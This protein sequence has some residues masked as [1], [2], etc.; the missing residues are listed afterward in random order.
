MWSLSSSAK[1][2]E[3]IGVEKEEA[4]VAGRQS[5]GSSSAQQANATSSVVSM[6][7]WS[8][9]RAGL[10]PA[11]LRDPDRCVAELNRRYA[12]VNFG[13]QVMI[14]DDVGATHAF[15]GVDAFHSL[16]ANVL[17]PLK[18]R[19]QSVSRYWFT[20]PGRRQYMEG[21]IFDPGGSPPPGYYNRWTG[22][23]VEADPQGSCDLFLE[24]VREVICKGDAD[25]YEYV[26]NWLALMIQRP[27][28]LPG[29]ALCL[30]SGQGTGKGEFVKYLGK[31]VGRYLKQL[32]DRDQLFGRFTDHLDD[33][34]LVFADEMHWG[35]NK[36]ET[37]R[38]KVLITE[39]TRE[40]ERKYG[41]VM[42]V[43]N[44]IHL[45]V[46]SNEE[47]A[48]PAEVD[49]R[50]F[51]VLEVSEHRVGDFAYFERLAGERDNGG[52]E[53][54][55]AFLE[56]RDI[57]TFNPRSFPRTRA[58]LSQQLASLKPIDGWL[59]D[60]ATSATLP[61]S[62]VGDGDAWS[63]RVPKEEL[64]QAYKAWRNAA[65][66]QG[67]AESKTAFTK[68]LARFGFVTTKMQHPFG[69]RRVQ[70]YDVPT[71]GVLRATFDQLLGYPTDWDPV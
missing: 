54:L 22:F 71:I 49:D 21:M 19:N 69:S 20:H 18:N 63:Q 55:L 37:G 35:G 44:C 38:L 41:A 58:R 52:P 33:A 61:R 67:A 1:E 24:H 16:Y 31:I 14:A 28:V 59:H 5:Q 3:E 57:S 23:A 29:V 60:L 47:W 62:V 51:F 50:R 48:V 36:N 66:V 13:N 30:L 4:L 6:Q 53:A 40:S 32:T 2:A 11:R 68:A 64:F 7:S 10:D 9:R 46:A 12:V 34:L 65:K 39:E 25:C 42:K 45:I 8:A 43:K 17:V 27:G 15:L 56:T 70:A 26:L